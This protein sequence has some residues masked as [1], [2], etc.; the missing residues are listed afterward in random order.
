MWNGGLVTNMPRNLIVTGF[1][2]T[3]KS[4]AGRLAAALLGL[5]FVDS[6]AEIVARDGR[7]IPDIFAQDGEAAFRDIERAVTL[8]LASQRG[9]VIATGGGALINPDT[10]AAVEKSNLV[11]CLMAAPEVIEL[12]LTGTEGVRPLAANWRA[13]LEQR[14]VAYESFAHCIDTSRQSPQQTAQELAQ[15]WRS[16][17]SR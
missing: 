16:I 15:L 4:T 1:M 6:D 13:V 10:R 3:G 12:R 11:V 17:V 7:R 2:G 9:L 5:R 14:R 8:D